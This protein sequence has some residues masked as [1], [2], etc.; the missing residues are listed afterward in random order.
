MTMTPAQRIDEYLDS[1]ARE[2]QPGERLPSVR[3][4]MAEFGVSQSVVQRA[5][6]RLKAEGRITAETGRGMFFV[7]TAGEVPPAPARGRVARPAHRSVLFLRRSTSLRRGRRVLEQLQDRLQA[8]GCGV[9]E[10]SYT[11][12]GDAMEI[13]RTLP[14]YDACVMQSTFETITIDMLAATRR[15]TANIVIDGAVLAGTEVDAV[16]IEWGS[17]IDLALDHLRANGHR[18]IGLVIGSRFLLATEIGRIWYQRRMSETPDDATLIEVPALP[19]EDYVDQAVRQIV[20]RRDAKGRL[21]FSALIVWGIE[22]GSQFTAGLAENGIAIPRDLSV[23]LLGRTDLANE[24]ADFYTICGASTV[25][26][27]DAL[28]H[29]IQD[30]WSTPT[31]EHRVRFLSMELKMQASVARVR[32]TQPA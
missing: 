21:P 8:D 11:D 27:T 4:L 14:R 32:T 6:E 12:S 25:A 31:A 20:A 1:L 23:V 10:V 9:V 3:G 30:R 22:R 13:L 2:A 18:R 28:Y 24:H 15:K 19:H 7:G 26:Q 17:A 5:T 29:A 16:G